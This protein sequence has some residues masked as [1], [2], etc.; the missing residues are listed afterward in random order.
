MDPGAMLE[1]LQAADAALREL[2]MLG[3]SRLAERW[4]GIAALHGRVDE[5][6]ASPELLRDDGERE[7]LVD[8]LETTLIGL[9][10][11]YGS[12]ADY[13]ISGPDADR[14]E[15]LK[16]EVRTLVGRLR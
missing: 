3:G 8:G 13:S 9:Y 2:R 5:A 11:G 7:R 6:L 1:R 16:D 14:F 10:G 12:F 4:P 15:A